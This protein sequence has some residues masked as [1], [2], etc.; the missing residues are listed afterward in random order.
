MRKIK[1]KL[2]II[3]LS[4]LLIIFTYPA[5]SIGKTIA[6]K[7]KGVVRIAVTMPMKGDFAFFGR[8]FID[9]ML[10]SLNKR[11]ASNIKF[12]IVNLPLSAGG[13]SIANL[14]DSLKQKGVS[15]VIG[16]LFEGQLKYFAKYSAK[17][18]IPAI[19]PSPVIAKKDLSPFVFSY[20]MTLKQE[21]RTEIKYAR[22]S[23]IKSVSVIY[24][25]NGYG[26]KILSYISFF[27]KKYG[28]NIL[29]TTA[30][31]SNTV[32]FFNNFNGIVKFNGIT[33]RHVSAAEKAELGVTKYDLMHGITKSTPD[34]PFDA[35]FV[36]GSLPKMKL[37]LTQL[38][39]Y[40]ITGFPTFGLSSLDSRS[41]IEKNSF[42]MQNAIFPDGFFK[43][44]RNEIVKKFSGIYKK[45]YGKTPNILSGEGYDIGGIII[46]AANEMNFS[47]N[48]NRTGIE[49]YHAILKI[50]IFKGVCGISKLKGNRFE[51][52][53]YLF[54]YKNGKI[55]ILKNPL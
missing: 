54:R 28:I 5:L 1:N 7:G 9:G 47:K 53:L 20:G 30:Y 14:F 31:G 8:Q 15:A 27:S 18:K 35:L 36:I 37:I 44:D 6:K 19:T 2:F 24:P 42:Y 38:V 48:N 3:C 40:N 21:I 25:D 49:F 33:D 17:F 51:K 50:K 10:L 12:V 23:D 11:K 55:Y 43:N 29:N 41:F 52:S 46:K 34:I 39:Y 45:T 26:P 4:F 32:D 16:P 22:Y 13:K